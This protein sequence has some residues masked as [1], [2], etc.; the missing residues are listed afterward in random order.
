MK[1]VSLQLIGPDDSRPTAGLC[2]ELQGRCLNRTA[3]PSAGEILPCTCQ[4][5]MMTDFLW[6]GETLIGSSWTGEKSSL[7][8]CVCVCACGGN[9][10][11]TSGQRMILTYGNFSVHLARYFPSLRLFAKA[12]WT[13]FP[14][15]ED[16]A[17]T[18][19]KKK[20][21]PAN[22]LLTPGRSKGEIMES[23]GEWK[24]TCW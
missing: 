13:F 10:T 1:A 23:A 4:A 11:P 17:A 21:L 15:C 9:F 12:N 8:L 18:Y 14:V 7:R 5:K 22:T 24:L 6:A 20:N 3:E 2:K 19:T 16:L